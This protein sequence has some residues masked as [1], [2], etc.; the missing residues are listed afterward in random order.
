M[1]N[2]AVLKLRAADPI[3]FTVGD[4]TGIEKGAIL[5][6]VDARTASGT[7]DLNSNVAGIAAREKVANDGRTQ[8]ACFV[9]GQRNIFD[10]KASG[11]ITVGSPVVASADNYVAAAG[12]GASGAMILGTA[13]ETA[14]DA[15]VI[16]VLV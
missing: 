8:L 6:L 4:V 16:E 5:S 14:T 13:L 11:A 1:A 7:I 12:L 3:D 10:L 15:E 2:E 9:P